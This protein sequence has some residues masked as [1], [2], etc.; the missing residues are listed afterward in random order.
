[1]IFGEGMLSLRIA[2][3]DLLPVQDCCCRQARMVSTLETYRQ[4]GWEFTVLGYWSRVCLIVIK[5]L[6]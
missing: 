2:V 1:V 6:L 5:W 3:L 4:Q